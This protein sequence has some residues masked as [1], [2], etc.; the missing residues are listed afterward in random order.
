MSSFFSA[1]NVRYD[2]SDQFGSK[3]TYRIAP[4][5]VISATGTQL[6]ASLGTGFKA[7][8]AE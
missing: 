6:K 3:V 4:T 8:D 1:L 5:Y 2:D 7:T